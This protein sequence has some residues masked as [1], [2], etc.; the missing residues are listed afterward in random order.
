MHP[1]ARQRL[2]LLAIVA[3]PLIVVGAIA[4]VSPQ[5]LWT[6]IDGR[7]LAASLEGPSD[8]YFTQPC[9]S[10]G[11]DRWICEFETDPGSGTAGHYQVR[12]N[13]HGCWVAFTNGEKDRLRGCVDAV[14]YALGWIRI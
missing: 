3:L 13:E 12:L 8:Y 2:S 11:T 4:I 7:D 14:D 9:E 6:T 1:R 10:V 5:T